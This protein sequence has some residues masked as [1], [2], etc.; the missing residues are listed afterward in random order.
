MAGGQFTLRDIRQ[1]SL[2][3]LDS[4]LESLQSASPKVR[5]TIMTACVA[6]VRSHEKPTVEKS[7]MLAL[8]ADALD[9]SI[10]LPSQRSSA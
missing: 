3:A 2:D 5:K 6:S 4:S 8:V 7:E 10:P 1:C 9:L